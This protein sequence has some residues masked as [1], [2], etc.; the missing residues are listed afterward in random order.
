MT[1]SVNVITTLEFKLYLGRVGCS[2]DPL[3]KGP[4]VQVWSRLVPYTHGD[5]ASCNVFLG[6][7]TCSGQKGDWAFGGSG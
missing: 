6:H 4:G 2:L 5:V 3:V 1:V 7:E